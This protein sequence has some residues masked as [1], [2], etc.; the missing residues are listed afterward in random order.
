MATELR[1]GPELV[2]EPV[3]IIGRSPEVELCP[4]FR[5][6]VNPHATHQTPKNVTSTHRD[7]DGVASTLL[8]DAVGGTA[9]G[10]V[11]TYRSPDSSGD[12]R[13]A[14]GCCGASSCAIRGRTLR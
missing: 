10:R 12:P 11:Y 6:K 2:A 13:W 4:C 7:G 3:Q 5:E 14:L 9:T 8:M 1:C